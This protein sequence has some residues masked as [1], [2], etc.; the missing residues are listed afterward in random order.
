MFGIV[1]EIILHQPVQ[2]TGGKDESCLR[3]LYPL[4]WLRVVLIS[5]QSWSSFLPHR[6]VSVFS[7]CGRRM[8]LGWANVRLWLSDNSP[9]APAGLYPGRSKIVNKSMGRKKFQ[10][11]WD[12]IPIVSDCHLFVVLHL[13]IRASYEVKALFLCAEQEVVVIIVLE[14]VIPVGVL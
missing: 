5:Y 12:G 8:K 3:L 14:R 13:Q 6:R 2:S 1:L 9:S 11:K 4:V 10:Q 7:I